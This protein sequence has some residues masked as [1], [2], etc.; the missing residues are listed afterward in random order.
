MCLEL[1]SSCFYVSRPFI[2]P[3]QP[4][5]HLCNTEL[6]ILP[7]Q[8]LATKLNHP[9]I[10]ISSISVQVSGRTMVISISAASYG[11]LFLVSSLQ[12]IS[13]VCIFRALSKQSLSVLPSSSHSILFRVMKAHASSS[14]KVVAQV[15]AA[16]LAKRINHNFLLQKLFSSSKYGLASKYCKLPFETCHMHYFNESLSVQIAASDRMTLWSNAFSKSNSF[17]LAYSIQDYA[18]LASVVGLGSIGIKV[19]VLIRY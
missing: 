6:P 11:T 14:A 4:T 13:Y 16:A 9:F 19:L 3:S 5:Y 7:M 15:I 8:L 18:F 10:C 1:S 12:C 17:N 2:M